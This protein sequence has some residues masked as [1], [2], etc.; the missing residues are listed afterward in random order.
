MVI[1][2]NAVKGAFNPKNITGHQMLNI[3]C[4]AK[5]SRAKSKDFLSIFLVL[6]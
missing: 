6:E 3:I 1:S 5:I 4:I 2:N